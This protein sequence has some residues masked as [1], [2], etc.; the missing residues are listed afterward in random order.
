MNNK[1]DEKRNETLIKEFA[2]LS[3]GLK[4]PEGLR[5]SN[6][7]RIADALHPANAEGN[8]SGWLK[9][10]ISVP[11]P[12]AACFLFIFCL[13]LTLQCFNLKSYFKTPES[14]VSD[15]TDSTGLVEE[16]LQ[17]RYSEQT[18]YV[19]GTGFVERLKSY[20]YLKE[21]SYESN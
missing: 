18:V 12:V 5:D 11:F 19:A 16:P 9:R 10:R 3:K 4:T 6:R 2:E 14:I 20:A 13:Q 17:L 21:S 1:K 7:R 15:G 8:T